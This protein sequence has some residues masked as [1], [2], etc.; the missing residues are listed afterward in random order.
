M[1]ASEPAN[2]DSRH[3]SPTATNGATSAKPRA[4]PV[5]LP[6]RQRGVAPSP[7][8]PPGA[9]EDGARPTSSADEPRAGGWDEVLAE[10]RAV[11]R[12]IEAQAAGPAELLD[13]DGAAALLGLSRSTFFRLVAMGK[14]PKPIELGTQLR[15]WRR[16]ALLAALD[17]LE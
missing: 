9:Q 14:L 13:A 1:R 8:T 3:E 16:S 17:D 6:E 12:A 5:P 7:A 10:L 4:Q 11:R 2:D 15:R